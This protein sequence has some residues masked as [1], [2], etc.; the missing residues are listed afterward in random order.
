MRQFCI[1][2]ASILLG[3]ACTTTT[4]VKPLASIRPHA[5]VLLCTDGD[6]KIVA[7]DGNQCKSDGGVHVV[8]GGGSHGGIAIGDPLNAVWT[9]F[10]KGAP[11]YTANLLGSMP[12]PLAIDAKNGH[13]YVLLPLSN[14]IV[15]ID[16]N[17]AVAQATIKVLDFVALPFTPYALTL[18]DQP[19][20]RLYISDP[21]GGRV[22]VQPLAT[23]GLISAKAVLTGGSPGQM[24]LAKA[25][26]DLYIGHLRH[27]HATVLRPDT[28]DIVAQ[29]GIGPQCDDGLD[30]D[31]DGQTDRNDRGCDGELDDS[32][33]NP[34][35]GDNACHNFVDDDGDG[36][37]DKDDAEC[38]TLST[39]DACRD[40]VDND[41]DGRT[42][43]NFDPALSDP[44]C[45]GFG[46][47]TEWSDQIAC[48][49]LSAC[50]QDVVTGIHY[51]NSN[52]CSDFLDNDGDG[53][54]DAAD[55]DCQNGAGAFEAP[56]ACAD[57]R[58]N[59]GDGLTD[60]ADADCYNRGSPAEISSDRTPKALVAATFDGHYVV[61]AD[62]AA[63]VLLVFDTATRSLILPKPDVATSGFA[64]ASR[65]D[66]R[67]GFMG[68]PLAQLP[69]ALAPLRLGGRDAMAVTTTHE[70]L[71][72][73][74]FEAA[75]KPLPDGTIPLQQAIA[76]LPT[77]T[78]Q[79]TTASKP[80]LTI[81]GTVV[82]TS[83]SAVDKRFASLGPL[84]AFQ[85]SETR[86]S[87]YGLVF[88]DAQRDQRNEIWRFTYEGHLPG[89]HGSQAR[90][91]DNYRWLHDPTADFC[92]IGVL[93]GDS[94]LLRVPA[95][96]STPAVVLVL[97][98]E[99][100]SG[101]TL[102]LDPITRH[103]DVVI[104]AD[105]QLTVDPTAVPAV[106]ILTCL[107]EGGVEYE[108]RARGW[109]VEGTR[110]GLLSAR[111][112]VNGQCAALLPI[113]EKGSRL[114][115]PSV[116]PGVTVSACPL[117]TSQL[118]PADWLDAA[119]WLTHPME[120]PAFTTQILPGCDDS[121]RTADG[122]PLAKIL[123]SIRDAQ[124]SFVVN[125]SYVT[126][127]ASVGALPIAAAS[128]P[129]LS[130]V[131]VADESAAAVFAIEISTGAVRSP[132]LQ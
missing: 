26:G 16:L 111:A 3:S 76:L 62:R 33:S 4:I 95:C 80:T 74:R 78:V 11:G 128:G 90:L 110:T 1:A 129:L 66:V 41:G 130:F 49:T 125:S 46:D 56:P 93:P 122:K 43:F 123:P 54:T 102:G 67:Q 23:F 38:A 116:R 124:W 29:I 35:A 2:F 113:D 39:L 44:G 36:L 48:D 89:G 88:N 64:R 52:W 92:R 98:V 51:A 21:D 10:D 119:T 99:T 117:G 19:E 79:L 96:G 81:P 13:G 71:Q 120:H 28:G 114:L 25:S 109:L 63:R 100:V 104:T 15:K 112:T 18:V 131:Y 8:I 57:G 72:I 5:M 69:L 65:L 60:L 53:L 20:P 27:R 84:L 34:E 7:S 86:A 85:F 17:A 126:R 58:D 94:V 73:L 50:P 47:T 91:V 40:G 82:D 32:E 55:P 75:Q 68:L 30:N 37:T 45:G 121:Q 106:P 132:I 105:N 127:V 77:D 14:H 118:A 70:G 115:E 42:D 108:V 83:G 31:G 87:N 6:G 97:R 59:D 12:G 9:D 61:M 107:R 103:T 101:D 24:A 22:W